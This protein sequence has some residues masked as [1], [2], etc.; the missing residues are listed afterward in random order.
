[1]ID[2]IG[3]L[4]YENYGPGEWMTKKGD[5]AKIARR[6]Y[7]LN[8][9]ELDSVSSIVGTIDKPALLLDRGSGDPRRGAGGTSRRACRCA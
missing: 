2:G 5:P 8:D 3:E 4:V 7:L 9:S 6:R 1:M